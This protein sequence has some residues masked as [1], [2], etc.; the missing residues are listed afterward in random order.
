MSI[1]GESISVDVNDQIQIRQD[2]QGKQTRTNTDINL[3]S[4]TNAW[5]KLASSVRVISQTDTEISASTAENKIESIPTYNPT[6][7]KYEEEESNIS[8]GEQRLRDLGLDNTSEFTGNQ[9]AKKAV[10]FNTLSELNTTTKTYNSRSGVSLSG[11]LWNNSSYGL[12]STDFGIVPSPG[13]ISAKINCLNRG[14]IREATVELKAY[15]LFQFQLIELLY[16][17]LGYTMLLE[18]GW[19]K[20]LD[21]N[22]SHPHSNSIVYPNLKYKSSINSN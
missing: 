13:L 8:A 22:L 20:Y 6:T 9:L 16:L 1:I 2:L 17:R 19:D 21:K 15:N 18:W 5:L 12:G 7:G 10:L 3:L 11:N 4:N 14:S